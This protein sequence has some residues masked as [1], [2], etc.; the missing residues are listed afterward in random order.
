MVVE[1]DGAL[2]VP[3]Y[4]DRQNDRKA[5]EILQSHLPKHCV[6]GIDCVELIWGLGYRSTQDRIFSTPAVTLNPDHRSLSLF[7][8]FVQELR[9]VGGREPPGIPHAGF[10]LK[11]R[12]TESF[13]KPI[14]GTVIVEY[15]G[16]D[17]APARGQKKIN[18]IAEDAEGGFRAV[19]HAKYF[20]L[21][22]R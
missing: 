11:I 15:G 9:W 14:S 22:P 7:S 12:V 4:R 5:I 20:E 13:A 8:G 16:C 18:V 1:P 3:T 10:S 17:F 19:H 6:I 21:V 2:L